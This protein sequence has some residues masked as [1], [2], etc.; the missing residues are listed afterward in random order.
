[1]IRLRDVWLWAGLSMVGWLT[2]SFWVPV[3]S[4]LEITG[5][6]VIYAATDTF[7]FACLLT[8]IWLL[9]KRA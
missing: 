2:A 4:D 6:R 7:G 8:A 3:V 9:R 5:M 1:M